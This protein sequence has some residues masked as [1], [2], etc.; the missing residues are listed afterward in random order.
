M[1]LSFD[2]PANVKISERAVGTGRLFGRVDVVDGIFILDVF[3]VFPGNFALPCN[4]HNSIDMFSR[5]FPFAAAVHN[6]YPSLAD[7]FAHYI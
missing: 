7:L 4:S 3:V 1:V 5:V 6:W 2:F